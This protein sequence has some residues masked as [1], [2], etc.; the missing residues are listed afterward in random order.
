MMDLS[1]EAYI[2]WEE[3]IS[4][5]DYVRQTEAVAGTR[6][7]PVPWERYYVGR[8]VGYAALKPNAPHDPGYTGTFTRRVF[9]LKDYDRDSDP[10]GVYE[11][12]TPSEAVDP[13]TVQPGVN[14]RQTRRSWNSSDGFKPRISELMGTGGMRD[15]D[16]AA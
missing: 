1:R 3:D 13:R 10:S 14:G 9:Y 8:R 4:R 16:G 7:R 5:L 15:G 12:G 2:V 6:R 11:H